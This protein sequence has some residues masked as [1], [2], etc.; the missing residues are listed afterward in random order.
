MYIQLNGIGLDG[1]AKEIRWDLVAETGHGPQM[2]TIPS[3]ILAKKLAEGSLSVKGAQACVGL[4][5]LADFTLET[6]AWNI[7]QKVCE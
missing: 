1:H 7:W 3:I 5:T 4:V 6:S 2:P